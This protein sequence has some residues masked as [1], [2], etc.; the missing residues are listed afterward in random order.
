MADPVRKRLNNLLG[1][2]LNLIVYFPIIIFIIWG[3]NSGLK[4]YFGAELSHL[5]NSIIGAF[6]AAVILN[7]SPKK[8]TERGT[9]VASV[10]G[11]LVIVLAIWV[12]G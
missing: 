8:R 11:Y 12:F 6:G 9:V 3:L 1:D 10:V 7:C 4:R 5:Q 2:L